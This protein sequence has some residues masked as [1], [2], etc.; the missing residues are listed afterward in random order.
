MQQL[1]NYVTDAHDKRCH[2]SYT[3]ASNGCLHLCII[4][5]VY[6]QDCG[7]FQVDQISI[8]PNLV[9]VPVADIKLGCVD[10]FAADIKSVRVDVSASNAS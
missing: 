5:Q 6:L 4:C 9:D 8:K 1:C 2:Q 7:A 3:V 10:L